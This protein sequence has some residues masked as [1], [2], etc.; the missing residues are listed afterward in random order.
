MKQAI[1]VNGVP[2]SGKSTV[3]AALV[4][5]LTDRGVAA[6]PL[7]LDTIKEG[8][9]VHVGTGDRAHN[10]MLGRASYHAIFNTVAAF[11]ASLVPIIDAWHGFEPKDVL[12][13]HVARAGIERVIEVWCAVSPETA[14]ARYRARAQ[15]RHAGHLPSTYADE[16]FEL[17]GRARPM[18]LGPVL[19]VDTENPIDPGL[20]DAIQELI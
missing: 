12:R 18:S 11:P 16:L 13:E 15:T 8:L 17:A 7:T 5:A 2:A 10:R 14:A 1:I 6:V 19:Q 9:F 3:T 20:F 4:E